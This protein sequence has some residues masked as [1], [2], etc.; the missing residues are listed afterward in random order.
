MNYAYGVNIP[1]E[2][3]K[4]YMI[5]RYNKRNNEI[6]E[7]FKQNNGKLLVLNIEEEEDPWKLLCEFLDEPIPDKPFPHLNKNNKS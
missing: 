1:T 5:E 7:Y 4:E 2:D 3:N 6:I